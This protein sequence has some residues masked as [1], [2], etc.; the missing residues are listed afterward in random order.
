MG[1]RDQI[2][3]RALINRSWW[4]E[5]VCN[6]TPSASLSVP[7]FH[8]HPSSLSYQ[9]E[10]FS[11]SWSSTELS[12]AAAHSARESV[13]PGTASLHHLSLALSCL[14]SFLYKYW[15][16][17]RAA[18]DPMSFLNSPGVAAHVRF[19]ENRASRQLKS[20]SPVRRHGGGPTEEATR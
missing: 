20:N 9:P 1:L 7:V 14:C 13:A 8:F 2:N 5:H 15:L 19:S 6:H 3:L 18:R 17:Q 4:R 16:C 11:L 10:L 12:S